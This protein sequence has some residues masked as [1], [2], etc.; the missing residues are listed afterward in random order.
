LEDNLNTNTQF[1]RTYLRNS[2]TR[3]HSLDIKEFI[4]KV[5]DLSRFVVVWSR[6]MSGMRSIYS[7]KY[8]LLPHRVAPLSK[9]EIIY[10][11]TITVSRNNT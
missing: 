9:A 6:L 10:D 3:T 2:L 4:S 8:F 1:T 7:G 11:S 5:A